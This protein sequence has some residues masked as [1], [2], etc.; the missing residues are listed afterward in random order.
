MRSDPRSVVQSVSGSL[1]IWEIDSVKE[2]LLRELQEEQ[3]ALMEDIE[4][5]QGLL[6]QETDLQVKQYGYLSVCSSLMMTLFTIS[7][8]LCDFL[9][10][11]S[12]KISQ[13]AHRS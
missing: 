11:T 9:I 6:E 1:N 13:L 4:Y 7:F 10:I 5:L 2:V 3:A 12:H 8:T